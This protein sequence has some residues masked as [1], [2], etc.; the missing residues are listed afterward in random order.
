[1]YNSQIDYIA[2]M[3]F[4]YI[5]YILEIA[6]VVLIL[7]AVFARVDSIQI[8]RSLVYHFILTFILLLMSIEERFL[9]AIF[10]REKET[11]EPT[12]YNNIMRTMLSI[13]LASFLSGS[14][15][16]L[17]QPLNQA[18]NDKVVQLLLLISM[19]CSIA[20]S[21]YKMAKR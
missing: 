12:E 21:F 1:M 16:I 17:F 7:L 14:S 20:L 19:I 18:T 10:L 8:D 6:F 11:V 5:R 3:I 9:S 13:G 15:F 4:K 2:T